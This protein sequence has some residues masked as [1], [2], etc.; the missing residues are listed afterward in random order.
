MLVTQSPTLA[1][2]P[3]SLALTL[4]ATREIPGLHPIL[5]PKYLTTWHGR[6]RVVA[7]GDAADVLQL[8]EEPLDQHQGAGPCRRLVTISAARQVAGRDRP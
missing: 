5:K 1:A 2:P 6:E 8:K 4:A 7:S 3:G